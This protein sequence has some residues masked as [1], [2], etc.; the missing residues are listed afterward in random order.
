MHS[1]KWSLTRNYGGHVCITVYVQELL[2]TNITT[3]P[4]SSILPFIIF[5]RIRLRTQQHSLGLVAF[6]IQVCRCLRKQNPGFLLLGFFAPLGS[7][8]LVAVIVAD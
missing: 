2:A 6:L 8:P 5:K 3:S 1:T 4:F 7:P